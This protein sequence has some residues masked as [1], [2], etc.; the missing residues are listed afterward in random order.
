MNLLNRNTTKKHLEQFEIEIAELLSNEFPEFKK[1]I[2]K[3]KLYGINFMEKPQG[4][5]LT[6]G[7]KPKVYEEIKRNHDKS[8]DLIGILVYEKKTKKYI[9]IKLNYLYNSL[10][11][12]EIENPKQFHI[13]YDLNN[14]KKEALEIKYLK[15]ENP[16]KAI[17][18]KI[19]ENIDR[20]KLSLLDLENTIEIEIDD[21][22]FF[23]I[24]DME[25]GNY[26]AI[27]KLGKVYCLKHDNN[28]KAKLLSENTMAFL[29]IFNDC[30]SEMEKFMNE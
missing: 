30:K 22:T 24:L 6:R 25:D 20:E 1:T 29:E 13:I 4:I 11:K 3:S 19:L 5:Y 27:D 18:L 17:V 8:F 2:E 9:P 15:L 14:I 12:I 28:K 26:I 23:T 16:D 10:A 21:K 7:Y